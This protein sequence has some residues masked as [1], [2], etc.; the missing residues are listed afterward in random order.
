MGSVF[1]A[2]F[3]VQSRKNK[4]GDFTRGKP[5]HFIVGGLAFTLVLLLGLVGAVDLIV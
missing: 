3:G 2:S 1:A 4:I 5:L